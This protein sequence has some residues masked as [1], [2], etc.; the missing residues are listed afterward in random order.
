MTLA[1]VRA[2]REAGDHDAHLAAARALVASEP[3]DAEAQ[4][5]AAYAHDRVGLERDAIRYYEAAHRLGVPAAQRRSFTVGFGSTLRNVGRA[6]EAVAF[7]AQAV[8]EDPEYPAYAAFL[9]LALAEAGHPRAALAAMLGCALDVARPGAFDRYDRAL[10]E[11]H[12]ALLVPPGEA[13]D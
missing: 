6:D 13:A 11:Y 5:E 4:L 10:T 9:A 3:H 2:L 8:A 7:L 1:E 12:R